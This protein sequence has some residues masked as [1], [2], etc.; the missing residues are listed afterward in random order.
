MIWKTCI[1]KAK[2][3]EGTD[4]L[5][6]PVLQSWQTVAETKARHTP[7]TDEQIALEGREVTRTEQRFLLPIPRAS[8]PD[9][10]RAEI[11][12]IAYDITEVIDL[13]PRWTVIQGKVHKR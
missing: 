11:G 12:G 2:Q 1:L 8:I 4:A 6:N 7:W 5:G 13:A 10:Q 9:F 3:S